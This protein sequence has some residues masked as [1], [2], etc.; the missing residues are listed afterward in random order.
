MKISQLA[1]KA[2]VTKDTV[3]H[4]V[5]IGLLSPDRD[6]SNGYQIFGNQALS[7]LRFIKTA[8]QLGFHLDDIQ[9]IFSDADHAHSPC[10]KVREM[11]QQRILET[12]K[13]IEELTSLCDRMEA[14][15]A[16]WESMP[17][18]TPDGHS[19]CRLIESQIDAPRS[20]LD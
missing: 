18:S 7:R 19:V 12:R 11:M 5:S 1:S 17:D 14:S 6:K 8:R 15:M 4:Y 10:P 20:S 16:E 2:G 9:R 3:R 13:T